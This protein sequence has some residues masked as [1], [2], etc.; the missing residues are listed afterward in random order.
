MV[1]AGPLRT[2]K[3]DVVNIPLEY[4]LFGGCRKPMLREEIPEGED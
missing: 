4:L 1:L 2:V 3:L